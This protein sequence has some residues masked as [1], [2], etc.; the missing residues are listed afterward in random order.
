M[1]FNYHM[2]SSIDLTVFYLHL[3]NVTGVNTLNNI[4]E[5]VVG[6]IIFLKYQIFMK[7]NKEQCIW[8]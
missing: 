1:K 7:R 5:Y 3:I 4:N 6:G 2:S 8:L